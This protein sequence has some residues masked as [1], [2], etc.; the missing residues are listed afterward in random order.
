MIFTLTY[1]HRVIDG[2]PAFK[3]MKTFKVLM[4]SPDLLLAY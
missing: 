3:F 4:E 2:A 1:D